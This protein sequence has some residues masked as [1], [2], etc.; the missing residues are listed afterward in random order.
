LQ[1]LLLAVD[2]ERRKNRVG[3]D[4]IGKRHEWNLE[5]GA[6]GVAPIVNFSMIFSR[7]PEL[8]FGSC[9]KAA[10]HREAA[11]LRQWASAR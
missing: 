1:H 11:H 9:L 2:L 8:V 4:E 6:Y 7:K 10:D 3:R 5:S